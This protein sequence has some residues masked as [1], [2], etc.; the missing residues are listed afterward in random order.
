MD[1]E[2]AGHAT[3]KDFLVV[4]RVNTSGT[5]ASRIQHRRHHLGWLSHEIQA[6]GAIPPTSDAVAGT[7]LKPW[8][9]HQNTF[10]RS[11]VQRH[12]GVLGS[13]WAADCVLIVLITLSKPWRRAR[14]V[15]AVP[16]HFPLC[17]GSS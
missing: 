11:T 5:L 8:E 9:K 15:P 1:E 12:L 17:A 2:L 14:L 16:K 13:T 4:R 3:T 7:L 10:K 6:G